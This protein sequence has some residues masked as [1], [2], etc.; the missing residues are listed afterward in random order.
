M[1]EVD[2]IEPKERELGAQMS[3]LEHL[4]ELRRRLIN[5]VIV[6][7]IAF[8]ICFAYSDSIYNFLAIPITKALAEA[9]RTKAAVEGLKGDEKIL[10]LSELKEGDRGRFVLKKQLRL[11]EQL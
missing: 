5:S 9:Q 3:F 6:I 2:E 1:E 7:V 8:L 10:S 11:K 4:D